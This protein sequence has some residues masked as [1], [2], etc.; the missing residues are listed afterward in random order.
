MSG[1]PRAAGRRRR[2]RTVG[3]MPQIVLVGQ[4]PPPMHGQALANRYLVE[5]SYDRLELHHVPMR[6]SSDLA[7][8]GRFRWTKLLRLAEVIVRVWWLALRGRRDALV[9]AVGLRNRLPLL[10]DSAVLLLARPLFR[11]TVL[12]VHSG[13][14]AE[15]LRGLPAPLATLVR[16][17]YGGVDLVIHLDESLQDE[18]LPA[19]RRVGYLPYGVEGPT[20]AARHLEATA[21]HRTVPRPCSSSRAMPTVLF[22]GN[23]YEAKGTHVLA[24]AAAL[25][26]ERGIPCRT[27]VAGSAP[28]EADEARLRQLIDELG[29]ADRLELLG[30]VD[31][32]TKDRALATADVFCFPTFYEAEALPLVVL[33]AMAYGLPVVSTCWRGIPS[34]VVEGVTGHL[35]V[36][37]DPVALADRLQDLLE[38]PDRA[39]KMGRRGR[40]RFEARYDIARFRQGFEELVLEALATTSAPELN[41]AGPCQ[42]GDPG[43]RRGHG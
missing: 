28:S 34:Q 12:H 41:P 36:P 21:R 9:V 26:A 32:D 33:E 22:L 38:H 6:F 31:G 29:L 4:V 17:A 27:V 35:V 5:G 14:W 3:S 24:R 2:G 42:P 15:Q 8:V 23:L 11:A 20:R 39:T 18:S 7:D 40:E 13:G 1:A 30:P 25:L 19:P 10:R 43:Q 37:G 16:R